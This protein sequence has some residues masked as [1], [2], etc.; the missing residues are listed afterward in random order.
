[1]ARGLLVTVSAL[2]VTIALSPATGAGAPPASAP[3]PSLEQAL[4]RL[5]SQRLGAA[6]D[7]LAAR[8]AQRGAK[9]KLAPSQARD[10]AL[11]L[12][13]RLPSSP[14][15]R[16]LHDVMPQSLVELVRAVEERS[17]PV[18]DAEAIAAYLV[19]LTS[20]LRLGNLAHFDANHSH[21]IGRHWHEIDYT[22]EGTTWQARRKHWARFGVADFRT[23][24]H[25]HRYFVAESKLGYFKRIYRPRGRM[26]DVA[27]P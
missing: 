10:A 25:V 6:A 15:L 16:A 8:V 5:R 26:A 21:V 4:A 9:M 1:M 11:A 17:L 18:G 7:V 19:R 22:G 20:T 23:A 12:A 13:R 27:A 24:T 2:V 3:L 14:S